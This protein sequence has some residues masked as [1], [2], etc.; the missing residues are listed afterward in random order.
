MI[1]SKL[2]PLTKQAKNV[3]AKLLAS[4]HSSQELMVR[5]HTTWLF[6]FKEKFQKIV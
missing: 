1:K 3:G 2:G 5:N 6:N 4:N